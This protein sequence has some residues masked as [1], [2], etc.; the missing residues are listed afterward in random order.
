MKDFLESH[1][2]E[3]YDELF[4]REGYY[5]PGDLPNL[6]IL[7]KDELKKFGITKRGAYSETP[8]FPLSTHTHTHSVLHTLIM[9]TL[10]HAKTT[11]FT[12]IS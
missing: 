9:S 8:S 10:Q 5:F 6:I 2:L 4:K 12:F 3:E 1:G 7:T 11:P